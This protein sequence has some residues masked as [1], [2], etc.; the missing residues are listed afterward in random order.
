MAKMTKIAAKTC[1]SESG[2]F[3]DMSGFKAILGL[4]QAT[5]FKL[6]ANRVRLQLVAWRLRSLEIEISKRCIEIVDQ[7]DPVFL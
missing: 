7:L 3:G 1:R 5:G 6:Q 4:G 2:E